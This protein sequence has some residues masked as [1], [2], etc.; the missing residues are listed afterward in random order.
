LRIIRAVL[1]RRPAFEAGDTPDPAKDRLAESL[2]AYVFVFEDHQGG[3][4]EE[5]GI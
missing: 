5:A 1:A 4:G 3:L 2:S